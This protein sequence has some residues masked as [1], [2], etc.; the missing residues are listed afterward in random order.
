MT[1]VPHTNTSLRRC[2]T[3]K[4]RFERAK[5]FNSKRQFLLDFIENVEYDHGKIAVKG[6][7]P[8]QLQAYKDPT[9]T[10]EAEKIEFSIE[11]DTHR[12]ELPRNALNR[13]PLVQKVL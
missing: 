11:D 7:V 9:Q 12:K 5:D 13:T 2:E 8:I 10:S 3:A 4:V 1:F 6:S